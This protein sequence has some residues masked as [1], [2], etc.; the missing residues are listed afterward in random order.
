MEYI[1]EK[2]EEHIYKVNYYWANRNKYFYENDGVKYQVKYQ[3]KHFKC[4]R[5]FNTLEEAKQ[6]NEYCKQMWVKAK[7]NT[8]KAVIDFEKN[9]NTKVEEYPDNLLKEIGVEEND[10]YFKI[11]L[12]YFEV[13]FEKIK[14]TLTPRESAILEKYYKEYKTFRAIGRE[15]DMSGSRVAQIHAKTIRKIR[16]RKNVF[17]ET[18]EKLYLLDKEIEAKLIEEAKEKIDKET[19]IE[20]VKGLISNGDLKVISEIQY[21]LDNVE[22]EIEQRNIKKSL[23]ETKIQDLDLSVRSTNCLLRA[24]FKYYKDIPFDDIELMMKIRNLGRKSLKEIYN[25]K[26]EL[27]GTVNSYYEAFETNNKIIVKP[28]ALGNYISEINKVKID[29]YISKGYSQANYNDDLWNKEKEIEDIEEELGIDLITF[30]KALTN[31]VWVKNEV[32]QIYHTN[33]YLYNLIS[34]SFNSTKNDF[35]FTT[36]ISGLLLFDRIKQDWALTKEELEND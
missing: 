10:D 9:N 19:A 16:I 21:C 29:E 30:H 4:E 24:G 23:A 27:E 34:S 35:C 17:Y 2:I 33:V 22:I 32:G 1:R 26:D 6:F 31:G 20:I 13:N 28:E 18:Q 5:L 7:Y 15:L 36:P 12:P 11:V 8:S 3:N 14:T 25:K